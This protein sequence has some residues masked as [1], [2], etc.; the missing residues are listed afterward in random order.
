MVTISQT[1]FSSA[2][3]SMQLLNLKQVIIEICSFRFNWWQDIICTNDG[4]VYC[5]IHV[6]LWLNGLKSHQSLRF[7]LVGCVIGIEVKCYKPDT[8]CHSFERENITFGKWFCFCFHILFIVWFSVRSNHIKTGMLLTHYLIFHQI[9]SGDKN[10][11]AFKTFCHKSQATMYRNDNGSILL[12]IYIS[13]V[14]QKQ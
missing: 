2:F 1:A 8:L 10:I 12:R 11:W 3:S 6:P 14:I 5:H 7:S 4:L 13:L 9:I